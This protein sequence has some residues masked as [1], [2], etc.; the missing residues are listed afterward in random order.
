MACLGVCGEGS[1][2]VVEIGDL[3]SVA[4][5]VLHHRVCVFGAVFMEALCQ[6][7]SCPQEVHAEFG[8]GI[9]LEEGSEF[10]RVCQSFLD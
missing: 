8:H 2:E 5:E 6:G 1:E 10:R 3:L 7:H 4:G 9:Y